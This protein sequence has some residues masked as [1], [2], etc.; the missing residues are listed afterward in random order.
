[1]GNAA[2]PRRPLSPAEAWGATQMAVMEGAL[3]LP[4]EQLD[5]Y[6][7]PQERLSCL[8]KGVLLGPGVCVWAPHDC[9]SAERR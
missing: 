1:M 8:C 3:Y 7:W 6:V 4:E 5:Y 2:A 9:L